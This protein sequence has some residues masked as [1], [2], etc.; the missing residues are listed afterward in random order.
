MSII[1]TS[2]AGGNL[3]YRLSAKRIREEAISSQ[4][5]D[6]VCVY[7]DLNSSIGLGE[8]I[9]QNQLLLRMRGYG[10]WAWKPRLLLEIFELSK[11]GDIICYADSGCQISHFG[12]EIFKR[13]VAQCRENGALFFHMSE[14]VEKNWSKSKLIEYLGALG[15]K[16]VTDTP[17][18][19]ATYF[20][21]EVNKKNYNLLTN[22]ANLTVVNNYALINDDDSYGVEGA[23]FVEH[24][25][26]QSI[27]SILVK[28]EKYLSREYECLFKNKKYYMNSPIM[29]YPIHSLRNRT[30]K[31]RHRLAFVYSNATY[32]NSDRLLIR[33][34]NCF[35]FA[36]AFI[37]KA[38]NYSK[39]RVLEKI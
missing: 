21:L 7:D 36:A 23:N 3:D 6:R 31:I 24:R 33:L 25:H 1:F 32:I 5:F 14:Y 8:F 11:P 37:I 2:F 22:W 29:L 9:G 26:D 35:I 39:N 28:Q 38:V 13:N 19:Q 10:Y 4:F 12:A 18:I 16:E 30:G 20:Y 17:M 27:L 15:N 34:M